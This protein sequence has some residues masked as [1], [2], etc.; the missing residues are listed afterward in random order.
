MNCLDIE[1]SNRENIKAKGIA[2]ERKSR[3]QYV[4]NTVANEVLGGTYSR[5][6]KVSMKGDH[7]GRH[8]S[9]CEANKKY[10]IH[11]PSKTKNTPNLARIL[12][13]VER[14]IHNKMYLHALEKKY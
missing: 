8:I 2:A 10:R 1:T 6:V 7:G 13:I 9:S 5:S 4:N 14:V 11:F 12:P 3:K